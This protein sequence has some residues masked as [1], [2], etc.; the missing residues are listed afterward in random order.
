MYKLDLIKYIKNISEFKMCTSKAFFLV[1]SMYN[2]LGN[3]EE[4]SKY[5]SLGL[6]N[7]YSLKKGMEEIAQMEGIKNI[8]ITNSI[9][10]DERQELAI[11]LLQKYLYYEFENNK[12]KMI[13]TFNRAKELYPGILWKT[14]KII[15]NSI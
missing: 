10:R 9:N 4:Y 12:E 3:H 1:S 13:N 6:N 2:K 8:N 11:I 14:N 7:V 15:F 5:K